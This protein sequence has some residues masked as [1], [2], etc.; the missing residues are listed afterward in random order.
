MIRAVWVDSCG[1]L[2]LREV[3][4]KTAFIRSRRVPV[5]GDDRSHLAAVTLSVPHLLLLLLLVLFLLL[6]PVLYEE[7]FVNVKLSTMG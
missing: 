3:G 6:L 7:D 1:F 2:I 4:G 5:C